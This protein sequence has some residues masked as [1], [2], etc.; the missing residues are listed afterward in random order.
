VPAEFVGARLFPLGSWLS[1]VVVR[2]VLDTVFTISTTVAATSV[3]LKYILCQVYTG[4]GFAHT[5]QL[6][7]QVALC[8]RTRGAVKFQVL[9]LSCIQFATQIR[10]QIFQKSRSAT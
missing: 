4:A 10:V 9:E 2:V 1:I 6:L 7:P 3:V 8:F 5:E